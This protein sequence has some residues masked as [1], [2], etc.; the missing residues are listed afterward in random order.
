MQVTMQLQKGNARIYT[1]R[2]ISMERTKGRGNF[3]VQHKKYWCVRYANLATAI[4]TLN[5]YRNVLEYKNVELF[6]LTTIPNTRIT[7]ITKI[8]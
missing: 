5:F 3:V 2:L 7:L 8:K 4:N 6:E 1:P